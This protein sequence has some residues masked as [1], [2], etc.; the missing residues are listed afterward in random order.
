[1]RGNKDAT[2][3]RIGINKQEL[4]SHCINKLDFNTATIFTICY[5]CNSLKQ[6]RGT[7]QNFFKKN[8]Y[9]G[10]HLV[11]TIKDSWQQLIL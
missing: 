2:M 11:T 9:L 8:I 4:K 10:M 1:M 6:P 3:Q 7:E 5:G